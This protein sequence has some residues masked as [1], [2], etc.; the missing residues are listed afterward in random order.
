[1]IFFDTP[2]VRE[3]IM[4][5]GISLTDRLFTDAYDLL[6]RVLDVGICQRRF[7]EL[8]WAAAIGPMPDSIQETR[9]H[10]DGDVEVDSETPSFH[11][12]TTMRVVYYKLDWMLSEFG[13]NCGDLE[14]SSERRR[15]ARGS[16]YSLS[17]AWDGVHGWMH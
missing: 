5:S 6:H 4:E 15:E 14:L 13:E 9:V 12:T 8:R 7:H 1:M 16:L 11:Y 17:R 2:G 3:A 10:G